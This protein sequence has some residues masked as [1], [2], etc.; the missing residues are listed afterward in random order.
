M[1]KKKKRKKNE[2][3][4]K[5]ENKNGR[6]QPPYKFDEA[7]VSPYVFVGKECVKTIKKYVGLLLNM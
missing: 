6:N 2:N 3:E 4:N 1:K 5:K 7:G